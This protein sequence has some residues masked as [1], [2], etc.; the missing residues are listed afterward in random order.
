MSKIIFS[1]NGL[2]TIIQCNEEE[3]MKEIIKRYLNKIKV[4]ENIYFIYNGIMV[5]EKLKYGEIIK[6][7]DK[8]RNIMNILVYE[9]NM[10]TE[11]ENINKINE[12]ICPECKENILININEYKIN[13]YNC[14]NKH[15]Y[16][17]ILISEYNQNIDISR[18]ICNKC[19]IKN[20]SNTYNN[21]IY[22]CLT[23]DYILC[24]LC[25]SLHDKDHIIINYDLKD[26]ICKINN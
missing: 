16:N 24:P 6:E 14:K 13:L 22:K 9:I 5:N 8:K 7:E 15:K 11:K 3:K 12:I 2:E 26:Y 1:Y 18:I 10:K 17:D 4:E 19:K 25:K 21:E 23:C 20:K